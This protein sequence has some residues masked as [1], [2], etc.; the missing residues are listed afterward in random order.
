MNFPVPANALQLHSLLHADGM[1]DLFLV[2]APIP[3]PGPEEVVLRIEAAPV[4]PSD[5]GVLIGG[6]DVGKAT[7][8][9]IGGRPALRMPVPERAMRAFAARV[10]LSIPCGNEGA[11]QRRPCSGGAWRASAAVA[12][13]VITAACSSSNASPCPRAPRRR[14]GPPAS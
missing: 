11:L 8:I 5:I 2:E 12:C 6:A 1:Q 9:E 4:N 13:T 3:E 10:G 7:V 14:R